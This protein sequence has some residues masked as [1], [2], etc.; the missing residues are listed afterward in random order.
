M[1]AQPSPKPASPPVVMLLLLVL[2]P[3]LAACGA[4]TSVQTSTR[5]T[6]ASS[7]VP[8]VALSSKF[9]SPAVNGG[10]MAATTAFPAAA[11]GMSAPATTSAPAT[12]GG[13]P[14]PEALPFRSLS[15]A[16]PAPPAVSLPESAGTSGEGL[17]GEGAAAPQ[18]VPFG[19]PASYP[20]PANGPGQSE[21]LKAGEID[22][23]AD[24]A[25][26]LQYLGRSSQLNVRQ[27]DV[28]ER[29]VMTVVNEN[30]QPVLDARVRVFE[31]EQQVFEGRTYAG[32]KTIMFPRAL[33]LSPNAGMLRVTIDKGNQSVESTLPRGDGPEHTYIL[34]GQA[35]ASTP[36]LDVL[37][38]LDATGSMAD[39]IGQIQRTIVSIAERIDQI[40]PRPT[41]RFGLVAYRDRGDDYV[42]RVTDFTA[43]VITFRDALLNTNADGGG[44]EPE[45]L[46][47]GLHA[48]IQG[49]GWSDDAVRLTFLVAD[50][51]PHLDYP[52]DY[53][54]V[55]EARMAVTS[56]IKIYTIAASNSNPEAEYVFRQ[57]AQQ[58]LA[59]FIFLTY[60]QGQN[61]GMPGDT[62]TM[63]VDPAAFTVEWL[64]D[65]VVQVVQRELAQAQGHE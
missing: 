55:T 51:P 7:T 28:Q 58:T 65:L 60:Q 19:A 45:A 39:E 47:E 46:N 62:T 10:G 29:Q 41:L 31:G 30:Q 36:Q 3:V 53:D 57:L 35:P 9:G 11:Q 26:Y 21:P 20:G 6:T 5:A 32:G 18:G 38:L 13:R 42:T 8:D 50:A 16:T 33:T 25:A 56:G 40:D 54:Y 48:A 27:V 1:P 15:G 61:G 37:F 52:D 17:T 12:E 4:S 24:F 2:L 59:H 49:V 34:E 14:M 63:N 43:D 23:N 64:D 44:D 22:D